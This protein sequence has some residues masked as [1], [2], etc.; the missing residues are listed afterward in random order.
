MA[1]VM[2]FKDGWALN[3]AQVLGQSEGPYRGMGLKWVNR[4]LKQLIV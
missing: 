3:S 4:Y 1:R 2:G